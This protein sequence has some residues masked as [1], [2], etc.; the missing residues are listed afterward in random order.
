MLDSLDL[1]A[2][3][4]RRFP[5]G[6][7]LHLAI[8]MGEFTKEGALAFI[9]H[10]LPDVDERRVRRLLLDGDPGG[11][12]NTWKYHEETG[13][14]E[15]SWGVARRIWDRKHSTEQGVPVLPEL[16]AAYGPGVAEF[17]VRVVE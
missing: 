13:L 5:I 7:N 1:R 15:P 10:L 8:A 2:H 16:I 4:M 6:E 12:C 9:A 3:P 17:A 14:S 11:Q